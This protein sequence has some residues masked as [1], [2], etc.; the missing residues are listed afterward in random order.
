MSKRN[1][2]FRAAF[3]LSMRMHYSQQVHKQMDIARQLCVNLSTASV[4]DT[5]QKKMDKMWV[6]TRLIFSSHYK[7][8]NAVNNITK[9]SMLQNTKI[10][11][12]SLPTSAL[13]I[14][15]KGG[16]S[17]V[18]SP[19]TKELLYKPLYETYFTLQGLK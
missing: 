15:P 18:P 14:L 3:N 10:E 13:S 8:T 9:D 17:K 19:S 7:A 4:I 5:I 12:S 6:G 2:S 16:E 1:E 11:V